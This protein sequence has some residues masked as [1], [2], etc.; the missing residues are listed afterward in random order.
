[1]MTSIFHNM[2]FDIMDMNKHFN[3]FKKKLDI[4]TKLEIGDKIGFDNNNDMYINHKSFF[5]PLIRSYYAQ[6]RKNTIQHLNTIIKEYNIFLEMVYNS[7]KTKDICTLLITKTNY[8][9]LYKKTILLNNNI[10]IGLRKL[11]KTY[12]NHNEICNCI[13]QIIKDLVDYKKKIDLA[14]YYQSY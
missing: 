7:I 2:V 9:K 14:I 12:E 13:E 3:I 6:N 5:Q 8:I 11:V 10:I 4:L 1:M